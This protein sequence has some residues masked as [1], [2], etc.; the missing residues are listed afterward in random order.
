MVSPVSFNTNSR[1][2]F[3]GAEEDFATLASQPGA[4]TQAPAQPDEFVSGKK[5]KGI[6]K[7]ILKTVVG[8]AVAAAALFGLH[9]WKGAKWSAEGAEGF[10]AKVKNWAVKPGEWIDN[11]IV[12]K[13]GAWFKPKAAAEAAEAAAEVVS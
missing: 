5:K 6:G 9:K 3:K 2:N 13:V 1:V 7:K 11:K 12:K 10:L 4:Y 8:L